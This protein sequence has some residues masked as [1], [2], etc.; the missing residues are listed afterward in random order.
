MNFGV[1]LFLHAIKLV[2]DNFSEALRV[3]LFLYFVPIVI[4]LGV[5]GG[6]ET[7]SPI[8]I[9]ALIASFIGGIWVAVAWHRFILLGEQTRGW[10]PDFSGRRMLSYFGKSILIGLIMVLVLMVP[11]MVLGLIGA[12]GGAATLLLGGA[13]LS[14]VVL[15]VIYRL[16]AIL[17]ASSVDVRMRLR[18]SWTATS[19]ASGSILALAFLTSIAQL[20]LGLPSLLLAQIFGPLAVVWDAISGW[21][22]LLVSISILTTLY[23]HFVE[24]RPLKD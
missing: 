24:G 1:K 20:L 23:G 12:Q 10:I 15:L 5:P 2:L 4:A 22:I 9:A 6:P 3:S 19:G 17:P 14:F 18:E 21:F 13:V 7:V 8:T 11:M 16:G